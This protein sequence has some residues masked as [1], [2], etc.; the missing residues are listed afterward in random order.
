MKM[1]NRRTLVALATCL[2]L[3]AT[4]AIAG[5]NGGSKKDSTLRVVNA[6]GNPA[7]VFVNVP[8]GQIQAAANSA[9]PLGAFRNLGGKQVSG[10]NNFVD[11]RVKA[12]SHTVSA[13]DIAEEVAIGQQTVVVSKGETRTVTFSWNPM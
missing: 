4:T 9:D 7:F 1:F 11:F 5:G 3:S 10:G 8:D 13:V 6:T 2:I 12:G